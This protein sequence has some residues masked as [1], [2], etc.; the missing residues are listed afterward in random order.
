MKYAITGATGKFGQT[1]IN[2]LLKSVDKADIIALARNLDK[3]KK[4]LPAGIEIRPGSYEDV[5]TLA[6][7]LKGVDKLLFISSI[8]GQATPRLVQHTNMTRAI[9]LAGV[10]FVAYTSFP[11][12]DTATVPL[13]QDHKQTERLLSNLDVKHSFLRNNWYLENE[14]GFIEEGKNNRPFVYSAGEGKTGWALEREYAEAAAKVLLL[15]NPKEIYELAG[16]AVTYAQLAQALQKAT[17]NDFEIKSV[18]DDEYKQ[19]L[20]DT[21]TDEAYLDTI[22]SFQ[23]WIHDGTLDENTTDLPEVLGHDLPTLE[24]SLKEILA[25]K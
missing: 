2:T 11:H 14:L 3:A 6:D 17:G 4:V 10:K 21:G 23:D 16:P 9:G 24:D 8:P 7:S 15:D 13:A 19:Y 22:I 20:K 18:S 12:A 5:E 1:V 25:R